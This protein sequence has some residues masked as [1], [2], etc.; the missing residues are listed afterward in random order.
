VFAPKYWPFYEPSQDG[1]QVMQKYF[2]P[3]NPTLPPNTVVLQLSPR[4]DLRGLGKNSFDFYTFDGISG[5]LRLNHPA[6]QEVLL[7]GYGPYGS[8]FG[9]QKFFG[10][11]RVHG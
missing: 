7:F 5:L 1:W 10:V 11:Q 6:D 3:S 8:P 9:Q 4:N 2:S